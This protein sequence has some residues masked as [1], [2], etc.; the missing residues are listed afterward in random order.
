MFL[1]QQYVV[2][3][4]FEVKKRDYREVLELYVQTIIS[5][6]KKQNKENTGTW[7][8]SKTASWY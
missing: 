6:H 2:L 7:V 8:T 5:L 3:N 1:C 4:P